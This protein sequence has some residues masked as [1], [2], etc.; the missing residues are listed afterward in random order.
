MKIRN[1]LITICL[2]TLIL[3]QSFTY[4]G[5]DYLTSV[6]AQGIPTEEWGVFFGTI[7]NIEFTINSS[8]LAVRILGP[9]EFFEGYAENNTS[10][11]NSTI[12]EDHYYYNVRDGSLHYPYRDYYP[13]DSYT[14]EVHS[15]GY[16]PFGP[17]QKI[18]M[19]NIAAP[20][21]AG[22]YT[23]FIYTADT[24]TITGKPD[25]STATS[26]NVTI[27]VS[28]RED[29][30]S[31]SGIIYDITDED[32]P[33]PT[34]GI[35]YAKEV[36]TGAM[37]RAY[38]D[39]STGFFNITGL[40]EGDYVV[41]AMAGF[42]NITN[43]AYAPTEFREIVNVSRGTKHHLSS[44]PLYRGGVIYGN[45]T[46]L[47]A[48]STPSFPMRSIDDNAWFFRLGIKHLNYTVQAYGEDG[49][50]AGEYKGISQGDKTW[51]PFR[52]DGLNYSGLAKQKYKLK[53]QI[54]GY[55]QERAVDVNVLSYEEKHQINIYV[56]S[57]GLITGIIK[58]PETPRNLELYA[59]GKNTGALFGGNILAEAYNIR[60][61]LKG[62]TVSN[63]T[64]ANDTVTYA[65][66]DEIRFY[67]LG[68][69]DFYNK[70]D[71]GIWGKKDSGLESQQYYVRVFLNGFV[72]LRDA[73][74]TVSLGH[75]STVIIECI[76]GGV[77]KIVIESVDAAAPQDQAKKVP[78]S[79]PK[80]LMR[81]WLTDEQSNGRGEVFDLRTEDI[82]LIW[83]TSAHNYKVETTNVTVWY[84]GNN[85]S[86][87]NIIYFG[88]I[89]NAVSNGTYPIKAY[90]YGYVEVMSSSVTVEL[91]TIFELGE[92]PRI[93]TSI[94]RLQ[95]GAGIRGNIFFMHSYINVPITERVHITVNVKTESGSLMGVQMGIE[96]PGAKYTSFSIYG[97]YEFKPSGYQ[98]P[99]HFYYVLESGHRIK[100][101]GL[102][103]GTYSIEVEEFGFDS[104]FVQTEEKKI[105]LSSLNEVEETFFEVEKLVLAYGVIYG[106]SMRKDLIPLSWVQV[107]ST[108]RSTMS[109]DGE[110]KLYLPG[111]VHSLD[112][113]VP[114]YNPEGRIVTIYNASSMDVRL[115][116]SGAPFLTRFS[117]PPQNLFTIFVNQAI[118]KNESVGYI[119][120]S[121]IDADLIEPESIQIEWSSDKGTLNSTEGSSVVWSIPN[122]ISSE[123]CTITSKASIPKYGTV[124]RKLV[125]NPANVPEFST[126][127]LTALMF[128]I[129]ITIALSSVR[130]KEYF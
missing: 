48:S 116:Q 96:E 126:M 63:R 27:P 34:P 2:I 52:I 17:P 41:T 87:D 113:F 112:F 124:E 103:P 120:S 78:W 3:I 97:L 104:R 23:F 28:M 99:D 123:N 88:A 57:G 51:D 90:T 122:E 73:P 60:G 59:S 84:V 130:R 13:Y 80:R 102:E 40:Y 89:P 71:S 6:N 86:V 111:G 65:D 7:G 12:T 54:F 15:P 5:H 83:P 110:F 20:S 105:T 91:P 94:V 66:Q 24:L 31:I 82:P 95:Q 38:T 16:S 30:S 114:G 98:T 36:S 118:T 26:E 14:I 49:K 69:S 19:K 74:V 42:C 22:D 39:P 47:N 9:R 53:V 55:V 11:L 10:F 21:I 67:I 85:W 101:Y 72:Q 46:Y 107:V 93:I 76:T 119:I 35:I 29:A 79:F 68:F 64:F 61:E 127:E 108:N 58:L 56:K 4:F 109:L 128:I 100:D 32:P 125:L 129:S 18:V 106:Y 75:N 115:F 43:Y 50:L 62:I 25:F 77:L 81:V 117:E 121:K 45:I 70:T 92:R 8:G 1:Q 33:I 37:A 44:F